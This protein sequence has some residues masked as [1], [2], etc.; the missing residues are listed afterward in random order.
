MEIFTK[1]EI[2][3]LAISILAL[4]I[5]FSWKPLPEYGLD[6]NLLPNFVI[7][8]VL[9]FLLHE[10]AHKFMARKFGLLAFYKMWPYGIL[11]GLIM[12]VFGLRFA[13]PG[14]VAIYAHRFSRWPQ[15]RVELQPAEEG[16]IAAVGPTVNLFLAI[17]GTLF[18]GAFFE[19]LVLINA[20]LA[21]INLLPV[22]PIDGSKVLHWKWWVWAFMIAVSLIL[23]GISVF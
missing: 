20:W 1:E 15:R 12:M 22:P 21:F 3:D 7:I 19:N 9:A 2:R 16:I 4:A 14:A 13:A 18:T 8:I 23:V 6:I 5:I 17:I 11:F 10:L